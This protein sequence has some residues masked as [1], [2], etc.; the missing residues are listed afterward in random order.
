M[1]IKYVLFFFFF[2][3][4]RFDCEVY[5]SFCILY[6]GSNQPS[7]FLKDF[8]RGRWVGGIKTTKHVESLETIRQSCRV[9]GLFHITS[10]LF[11]CG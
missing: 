11:C 1:L 6:A 7:V 4:K 3:L 9:P 8:G 2:W 10:I 5:R